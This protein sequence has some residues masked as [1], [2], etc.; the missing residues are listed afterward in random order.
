MDVKRSVCEALLIMSD[1][2]GMVQAMA[3]DN[4]IRALRTCLQAQIPGRDVESIVVRL[5]LRLTEEAQVY[6][7]LID[8]AML[9]LL[10]QVLDRNCNLIEIAAP[11]CTILERVSSFAREC[12]LDLSPY[13]QEATCRGKVLISAAACNVH[14]GNVVQSVFRFFV[15]ISHNPVD[16]PLLVNSETIEG[17]LALSISTGS[18]GRFSVLSTDL[19]QILSSLSRST[20]ESLTLKDDDRSLPSMFLCLRNHYDNLRFSSQVF[21]LLTK[22]W[23]E[24]VRAS[25]LPSTTSACSTIMSECNVALGT[26]T[27]KK[28]TLGHGLRWHRGGSLVPIRE[29]KPRVV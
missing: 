6:G 27:D 14:A 1:A 16:M 19:V 20:L 22:Y 25:I 4:A 24:Q 15:Q 18:S 11:V 26:L 29:H 8:E 12:K 21:A 10:F 23:K 28:C 9:P 5:L 17:L 13:V 7:Q 3:L 2:T